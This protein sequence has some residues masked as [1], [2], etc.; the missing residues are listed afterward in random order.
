[1]MILFVGDVD[2]SLSKKAKDYDSSAFLIDTSNVEKILKTDLTDIV[3][4][5]SFADLPKITE[6]RNIFFEV[7]I[8]ANVIYYSPPVI[9]SDHTEEFDHWSSQRITEYLLLEVHRLNQNVHGLELS[10]WKDNLYVSFSLVD[11]R[12][13]DLNQLWIAG[14]SI[15]HGPG[16][17]THEKIGEI[18]ASKLALPVSHLTEGGTGIPWAADQI[19]RS[20]LRPGDIL[21]WAVTS[22][23]RYCVWDKKLKNFNPHSFRSSEDR[24]MGNNLEN[25]LYR[26]VS[27]IHQ[28]INF[29]QKLGVRLI[30]LPTISSEALRLLFHDCPDWHAPDYHYGFVD[31]GLDGI[32]PGPKQHAEWADFCYK[33][34]TKDRF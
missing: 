8:K 16:I 31:I 34:I 26:A 11:Q 24:S 22:E 32:H 25:M 7:L 2:E 14:C 3:A 23:Y 6:D 12:R 1:M 27:S 21:V 5:T 28:V 19:L 30:L 9:W 29:C 33:I 20:D 4:Y 10:S 13:S 17:K 15:P 18:L